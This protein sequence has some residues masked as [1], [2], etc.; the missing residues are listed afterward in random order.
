MGIKG[1]KGSNDSTLTAE[2]LVEKLIS[3]AKISHKKMFGGYGIFCEGK[4]FG[5]VDSKGQAY[6]KVNESNKQQFEN[7]GAHQHS[8]MPYYSIPKEIMNN[9]DD[10]IEWAKTSIAINKHVNSKTK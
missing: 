3:I 7:N 1:D 8:K 4:M 6:L 2:L 5:M 9:Q 10:L